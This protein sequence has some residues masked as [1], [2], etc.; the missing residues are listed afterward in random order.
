MKTHE[1][2][3]MYAVLNN[4]ILEKLQQGTLPWKQTWN[5][6]GPARNYVSGKPYRGI[7]ALILGNSGFEY[8]LFITFLQ[9]KEL[10]GHIKKGSESIPVIYYKKLLVENG[11]EVKSIPFL[12]YYNV[13]NIDCVEGIRFK[14]PT[15]YQNDPI[16]CCERIVAEMANKPEIEHGGDEPHYNTMEDKVKIPVRCNFTTSEEYYAT[17]FHE[18]AHSTGH[19]S[20]LNRE[21]LIKPSPY[22]SR[23][24]CKEE[25][26]AEIAT[27]FLCGEAGI[28]NNIL[29]NSASYIKFWHDRLTHLLK[30][31]NKA[32]VR[33]SAQ[34][35]KAAD[36]ILNR[37][38]EPVL[39]S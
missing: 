24:Y 26:T 34:A 23:E 11:D 18:L 36:Y 19:E 21:S 15:R 38:E 39:Q 22:G 9:A 31:D 14:L 28:G 17:L 12:R 16:D 32:F 7:N 30:E 33:A 29:D 3:D 2:K 6:F 35:Q 4:M 8:P 20:R 10:G 5:S 25:L 1:K 37:I 27:C 13:F